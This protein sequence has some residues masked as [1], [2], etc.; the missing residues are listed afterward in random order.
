ME[1]TMRHLVWVMLEN[2][3]FDF[4]FG[5]RGLESSSVEGIR[6]D[7]HG[8]YWCQNP[9]SPHTVTYHNSDSKGNQYPIRPATSIWEGEY[10]MDNSLPTYL[11]AYNGGRMDGF[12]ISQEQQPKVDLNDVMTFAP[13]GSFPL[14]DHFADNYL[15][16]DNF[17]CSVPNMTFAN[18]SFSMS[19]TS[20][21]HTHNDDIGEFAGLQTPIILQYLSERGI[22]WRVYYCDTTSFLLNKNGC[23]PYIASQFRHISQLEQDLQTEGSNFPAYTVIEPDYSRVSYEGKQTPDSSQLL[24]HNIYSSLQRAPTVWNRCGLFINYDE[25][26]GF[27][28]HVSP[29]TV[30]P[31]SYA[32]RQR[33]VSSSICVDLVCQLFSSPLSSS[34]GVEVV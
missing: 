33:K 21:G 34:T 4:M 11:K 24:L 12:I 20:E 8:R 18:R 19:G 7:S 13:R 23:R 31:P 22:K 30:I 26:N 27:Y 15:L 9:N 25:S 14:M 3:S 17:F 2:R 32:I 10:R 16:Y 6:Q 1:Q 5:Y 28:D 29:P